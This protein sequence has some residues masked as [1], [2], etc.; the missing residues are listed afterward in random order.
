MARRE[1][2][3]E[4]MPP[5]QEPKPACLLLHAVVSRNIEQHLYQRCG[6]FGVF[7]P[8]ALLNSVSGHRCSQP[9]AWPTPSQ[10]PAPKLCKMQN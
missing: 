10:P 9:N 3:G 8:L 1:W 5:Q 6:S 2:Q 7:S 4:T